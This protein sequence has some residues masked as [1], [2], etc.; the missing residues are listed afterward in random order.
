MLLL[1]RRRI[2]KDVT[3]GHHYIRWIKLF[4]SMLTSVSCSCSSPSGSVGSP[5][6]PPPPCSRVWGIVGFWTQPSS[7]GRQQT[8]D[9]EEHT[10]QVYMLYLSSRY[11][12]HVVALIPTWRPDTLFLVSVLPGVQFAGPG[13]V[14]HPAAAAAGP[15]L[16]SN[17]AT[18]LVAEFKRRIPGKKIHIRRVG[19]DLLR[20]WVSSSWSWI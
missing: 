3:R 4:C 6:P 2:D 7:G 16:H 1:P 9:W 15:Q 12:V 8:L 5:T 11:I 18:A 19:N 17:R 10:G 20:K 13:A 14:E